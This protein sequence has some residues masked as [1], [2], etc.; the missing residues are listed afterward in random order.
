MTTSG[1]A[2]QQAQRRYM[3]QRLAKKYECHPDAK[4]CPVCNVPVPT[5]SALA[6]HFRT[7]KAETDEV[8]C[9]LCALLFLG[10]DEHYQHRIEV[11]PEKARKRDRD[12]SVIREKRWKY[13]Q[14]FVRRPYPEFLAAVT[15]PWSPDDYS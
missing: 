8:L 7:H 13:V 15:A 12:P 10:K 5:G 6:N 9:S 1:T 3:D 14:Q 4:P 11:H 2:R